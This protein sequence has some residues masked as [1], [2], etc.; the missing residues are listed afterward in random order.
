MLSGINACPVF[1]AAEHFLMPNPLGIHL[2]EPPV[3]SYKSKLHAMQ[4]VNFTLLNITPQGKIPVAAT[5]YRAKTQVQ[6]L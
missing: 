4:C 6:P 3:L 5:L 1:L 2:T